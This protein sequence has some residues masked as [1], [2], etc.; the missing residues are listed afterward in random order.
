MIGLNVLT[1]LA[2]VVDTIMVGHLEVGGEVG[3]TALGFATQLVF[4]LVV[5]MIGLSV[6][7]IALVARAYGA[8]AL[9]RVEHIVRQ[10]T[11][12]S[13][14]LALLV[15]V[16]GNVFAEPLLW[17][18]GARGEA[19]R[20]A[21]DYLRPTL[22]FL[23]FP[24]LTLLY[25]SVLRAVGETRLP[26]LVGLLTNVLNAVFNYGLILG[27]YG[28]PVLGVRGAAYGTVMA[29]AIGTA[30][31]MILLARGAVPSVV[32]R[33]RR[34]AIDHRLLREL[35]RVG[36]PAA[37]DMVV[38]NLSFMSIVGML[39]WTREVAVAAHG[40]GLRIQTLAFVPG[41]G[42]SQATG[43]MV[44]NALG[45]G[46]IDE[47]KAIVRASVG[48]CTLVM[49]ALGIAILL[50]ADPIVAAFDVA[51]GSPLARLSLTWIRL[52]GWGMPVMGIFI[53]YVGMMRGAGATNTSLM[54]TIVG[55]VAI[56]IPLSVLL[57]FSF[58]LGPFG[59]WVA[60]PISYIVRAMMGYIVY[61]REH[62]ARLGLSV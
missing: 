20:E 52:L 51:T 1:V 22:L 26:F 32:L 50:F 11:F 19:M 17:L 5:A 25:T 58:G 15:G 31:L 43:A 61:R 39:G 3:L 30:L 47:A 10:S 45:A 35:V 46:R 14:L 38:I 16:A 13:V 21:L 60:F 9:H 41:L 49:G 56:Q 44:G 18:L 40:I 29:Q 42:I 36:M 34:D 54:I 48:L 24:Y 53:A 59:I 62:W 23:V 57:G 7:V 55:T 12:H 28:L 6:G 8:D 37:L 27:H 4:L 33:L 2:L